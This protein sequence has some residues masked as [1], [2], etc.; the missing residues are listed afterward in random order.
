MKIF[1]NGE[2][3]SFDE[4]LTL[5]TLIDKLGIESKVMAS[6]VNMNVVK[7]E[8]WANFVLKESDKVE[9]LNFVGGG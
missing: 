2:E 6:A 8:N 4:S 5:Q 7:K 9:L 1:V 3:K